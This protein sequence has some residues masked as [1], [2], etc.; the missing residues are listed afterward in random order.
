MYLL[1]LVS[2][3]LDQIKGYRFFTKLD[4]QNGYNNIWIKDRDQ[5]KAAFKTAKGLYELMVIYFGLCNSLA[6]FQVFMD[7]VFHEQ[8]QKGGLL[9]YIDDLL[10]IGQ[11]II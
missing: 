3:L 1:P 6:T 7:N 9:I 10:I 2:D 11:T 8:K 5:W 4:L